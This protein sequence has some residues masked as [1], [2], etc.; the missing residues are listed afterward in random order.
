[1][2]T[3]MTEVRSDLISDEEV[4]DIIAL[5]NTIRASHQ[6]IARA[7][8]RGNDV[9]WAMTLARATQTIRRL[10]TP[11]MMQ[12][13]MALMG[14]PLG[15]RTDRDQE[16]AKYPVEVVRDCLIVG[17]L[18]G[19]RPVGNEINII[20][21]SCYLTKEAYARILSEYPGLTRLRLEVGVPKMVGDVGALVPCSASWLLDGVEDSIVC[22]GT[23][24]DP[25]G[26]IAVRVNKRMGI[27][28]IQ[29]KAKSKLL[30]RVYERITGTRSPSIDDVDTI[31]AEFRPAPS[32]AAQSH[33]RDIFEPDT[34][35]D[36]EWE[37]RFAAAQTL[38][39][40]YSA[41]ADAMTDREWSPE[42]TERLDAWKGEA[43]QR[44]VTGDIERQFAAVDQIRDAY[45]LLQQLKSQGL[46]QAAVLVAEACHDAACE[47]IRAA[48]G[49]RSNRG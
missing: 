5:D 18:R 40:V 32:P 10:L 2:N 13:V 14:S 39:Q 45:D 43:I 16:D 4:R 20:A 44:V 38:E 22:R 8:S 49:P 6:E 25:G 19:A 47:R 3:A 11:A 41:M 7:R 27:D 9:L 24:D 34:M 42:Q 36:A 46:D 12:D 30:R 21:G 1:M 17:V 37:S 35:P 28:A 26:P 15:F 33:S 31:D 23:V 48:R 29:G